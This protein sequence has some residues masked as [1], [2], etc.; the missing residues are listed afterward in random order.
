VRGPRCRRHCWVIQWPAA[1][2]ARPRLLWAPGVPARARAP[3]PMLRRAAASPR[4]ARQSARAPTTSTVEPA[5]PHCACAHART[6]WPLCNLFSPPQTE[7][8]PPLT[9]HVRQ[10]SVVVCCNTKQ[11][12][13]ERWRFPA[14]SVRRAWLD[15]QQCALHIRVDRCA[16]SVRA[17]SMSV[18]LRELGPRRILP[19]ASAVMEAPLARRTA[20]RGGTKMARPARPAPG[21]LVR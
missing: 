5:R 4:A 7:T 17:M 18:C 12:S 13:G 6:S 11:H 14:K 9:G 20:A 3:G 21:V 2:P 8:T 19:I 1:V 10:L 16:H 15:R